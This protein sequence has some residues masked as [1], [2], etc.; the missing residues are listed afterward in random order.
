M[1][2]YHAFE[3]DKKN[4]SVVFTCILLRLAFIFLQK[5][6]YNFNVSIKFVDLNNYASIFCIIFLMEKRVFRFDWNI[7]KFYFK[8]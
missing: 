1:V 8:N 7:E 6:L 3:V 4:K 5:K 2:E